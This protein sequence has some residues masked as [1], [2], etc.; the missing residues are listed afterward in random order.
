MK[1]IICGAGKVGTSIAKHLVEQKNDVIVIDRSDELI[2]KLKEKVDLKTI[3]GSASN[4]SIL[5]EAGGDNA[6]M[7]IAVTLQDEINMVA[8][9]MAHTFFQI[10]RKIARLRTEDF[11]N[12]KWR[13]LYKADN[14]PIDLIISPE[15]EVARSIEKQ[16]KAPGA[17]EVVPF[18]NDKVELINIS[19]DETCPLIDTKISNIID[20]FQDNIEHEE[21]NLRAS[22]V[23][24][25]R[26]DNL[27]IPNKDDILN[28][29]DEIFVLV[30]TNQVKRLMS[31]FGQ[32]LKPIKKIIVIGGG[33]IG[34][35]LVRDIEDYHSDISATII[36]T[37]SE[38]ARHIADDLNS[39]LVLHGDGLDQEILDEANIKDADMVLALTNDDET[40]IILSAVAKKN[41]CESLI[42]VNNSEYDKLKDVL[43]VDKLIN[44]RMITVSKIL[45]HIHKG[46]IES[47]YSI[48]DNKAEIIHA[49]ALKT[50]RLIGKS[51]KE[52][53]LPDGIKVGLIRRSDAIIVPN[54][55]TVIEVNDEIIFISLINE[56]EFAEDLFQAR[57]EY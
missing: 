32:D 20:L 10:P 48:G 18:M 8:C 26:N 31:A 42:L 15:L 23:A 2:S 43:G 24:I 46:K 17:N 9:Q 40:N 54:K 30:D 4:P 3:L 25:V 38:R 29:N 57:D 21:R 39:T 28:L 37:N 41:N 53:S 1:I 22:I 36:E 35:N 44:P 33:R 12:P 49:K 45:K 19:I 34:F 55:S 27:I 51:L 6:D 5:K 50:S 11:L 52:A 47:V 14:M 56:I 13:D 16:L 7:I